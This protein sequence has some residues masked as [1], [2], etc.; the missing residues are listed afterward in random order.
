[1]KFLALGASKRAVRGNSFDSPAAMIV[2]EAGIFQIYFRKTHM[3]RANLGNMF[4]PLT[5]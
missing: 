1:M 5:V 3:R 4:V 2:Q